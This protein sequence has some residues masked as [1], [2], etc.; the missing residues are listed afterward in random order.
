M[1]TVVPMMSIELI[2]IWMYGKCV[3]TVGP[4]PSPDTE[5]TVTKFYTI[6]C[7]DLNIFGMK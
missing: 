4:A 3:H 5:N 6:Y 2:T 7:G 1:T